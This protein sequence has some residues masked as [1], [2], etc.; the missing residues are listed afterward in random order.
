MKTIVMAAAAALALFATPAMANE[1]TGVR[2][3]VTAGFDDVTGAPNADKSNTVTYGAGVGL[4]AELYDNVI[5]GVEATVD[6]VFSR[7]NI[8]ASARVGYVV[9]D[10]VL[11]YGK[12]GYSN[13]QAVTSTELEGLRVGGG[14]EANLVGPVYAKAEYRYT[15]FDRGVGRHGGFV[16]VGLRF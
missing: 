3:E 5:V 9:A 12:V 15:D 8:G 14:V 1:F 13:W 6:N 2:A 7:R 4:D 10:T 11:V 16:G